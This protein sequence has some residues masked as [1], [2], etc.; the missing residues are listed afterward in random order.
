VDGEIKKL[1]PQVNRLSSIDKSIEDT[2]KR[3][4]LLDD[5]RRRSKDDIDVLN[6]ITRVL[7]PPAWASS[8]EIYR[9][10]VNIAGEAE[11]AA[12]LIKLFDSS[13]LFE[14]SEFTSSLIR[15]PTGE[16]FRIRT[17]RR[18]APKEGAAQ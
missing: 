17:N 5:F 9:N 2:R 6:E 16:A 18:G 7:A 1:E 8:V 4:K 3:T 13:K 12:P 15:V 11:Q 10:N 14:N